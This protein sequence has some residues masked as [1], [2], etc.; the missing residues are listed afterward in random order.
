MADSSVQHAKA[1]V[2]LSMAYPFVVE[3]ESPE[4]FIYRKERSYNKGVIDIHGNEIVKSTEVGDKDIDVFYRKGRTIIQ[5]LDPTAKFTRVYTFDSETRLTKCIHRSKRLKA[6]RLL[7]NMI[8]AEVV[9]DSNG[10]NG[11]ET[12]LDYEGHRVTDEE[13]LRVIEHVPTGD[14]ICVHYLSIDKETKQT[15]KEY[16]IFNKK[17]KQLEHRTRCTDE[18]RSKYYVDNTILYSRG[19]THIEVKKLRGKLVVIGDNLYY[20]E[21]KSI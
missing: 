14:I 3:T 16:D 17:G 19:M 20:K 11:G 8:V 1:L 10:I 9:G 4:L 7:D 13:Y 2:V 15:I 21:V 5:L 12:L 18:M 6:V